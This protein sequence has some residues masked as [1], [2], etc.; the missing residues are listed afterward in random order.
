MSILDGIK[1]LMSNE[2]VS[3]LA[4]HLGES[5][6]G[7]N[8]AMGGIVP[9]LLGSLMGAKQEDHSML[10]G[11]LSQAGNLG[12]GNLVGDLLGGLTGG[13]ASANSG[14]SGIGSSLI[15]GLL[16]NKLGGVV[17]MISSV[18]G[19]KSSSSSSLLGIGGSLIASFLGKKMLGGG[20][21][22]GII[23]SLMGEKKAIAAAAPSGI[24]GLLGLDNVFS[25]AKE[26]VS[27]VTGSVGNAANVAKGAAAGAVG[28]AA[29]AIT[30]GDDNGGGG[31]KWLWPVLLLGLLGAGIY[32]F[33]KGC[34]DKKEGNVEATTTPAT[35]DPAA[36]GTTTVTAGD[37]TGAS[38]STATATTTVTANDTMSKTAAP[39]ADPN[40]G[41]SA[42]EV[43]GSKVTVKAFAGGV[44]ERII[45]FLDDANSK[46][47]GD[48]DKTK[49]WYD[50][51]NLNFETNSATIT[52]GS[53]VQ[54]D[55]LAAI[56]KAYPT[57]KIKIG[58]YTDKVGDDAKNKTLSQKR[59][60]AV[61]AALG[62][63][64]VGAQITEAEGYGEK[65]AKAA[66]TASDADRRTDR[67]TAVRILSK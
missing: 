21:I 6:E 54:V 17:D 41:K 15:S 39:A 4:G 56:L 58:G 48:V 52:K 13:G 31:M 12:G 40:A 49:D 10:G 25:S 63:K 33:T 2:L 51:D 64:G 35:T 32:M 3:G 36:G 22:S 53:M 26:A 46:V 66:E 38:T 1:G 44:E 5:N 59:A 47:A 7:V 27:N 24:S 18:A 20:G 42:V 65:F 57:M 34:G 16:G 45:K 67:R 28:N 19:V 11:L 23:S 61:K 62:A 50:F 43:K 9:S 8:K 29:G 55:N 60:D 30:G 37:A 14:I